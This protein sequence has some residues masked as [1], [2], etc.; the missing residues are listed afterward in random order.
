M[1]KHTTIAVDLAKIVFEIGVSNTPGVVA[2]R[3]RVTRSRFLR[4]FAERHP[5]TVLMEACGTSHHWAR[6]IHEL[7][8]TVVLIHPFAVKPYRRR[9]KTDAADAKALL[10][11]RNDQI[12]PIPVKSLDQQAINSLHRL[13]SR[14]I[15]ARTARI[16]TVR[17]LLREFGLSIPQG[18]RRVAPRCLEW[19]ADPDSGIPELIRPALDEACREILELE[20]K[21][22]MVDQQLEAVARQIPALRDLISIPG[23]GVITATAMFGFVGSVSR[24]K[25]GRQFSNFLGLTPREHSSG[26]TRRLGRVSKQGDNYLRMLLVHGA[27]AVLRAAKVN[28]RD[29][30]LKIWALSVEKRRGHNKAAM[31]LANK[32]A[33]VVWSVWSEARPY[34]PQLATA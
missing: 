4:F 25:N 34:R 29:D 5:C 31:A 8:H 22:K 27:R 20:R 32:L 2:Q 24:F 9:N 7:G 13:R 21:R 1:A 18:A 12:R 19:L 15:A 17:G 26:Q 28:H 16:N 10:E 23:I 14:W 33:R 3:T 11:A 30:R 6:R